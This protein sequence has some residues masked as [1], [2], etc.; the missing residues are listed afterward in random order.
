MRRKIQ[1]LSED[2]EILESKLNNCT[3]NKAKNPSETQRST[4]KGM[5]LVTSMPSFGAYLTP[6][7]NLAKGSAI[8]PLVKNSE[9]T[10]LKVNFYYK[11]TKSHYGGFFNPK[12][13]TKDIENSSY[14]ASPCRA[15]YPTALIQSLRY[16]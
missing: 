13:S 1:E 15:N 4:T 16:S 9:N 8:L 2:I 7:V 11:E 14:E 6:E 10:Q 5:S 12:S 3:E